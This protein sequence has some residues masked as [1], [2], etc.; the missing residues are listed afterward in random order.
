MSGEHQRAIPKELPIFISPALAVESSSARFSAL[1]SG[2]FYW[3][4]NGTQ[5]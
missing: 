3:R 5:L 4:D 2:A 1:L